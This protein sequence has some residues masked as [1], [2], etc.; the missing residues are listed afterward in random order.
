MLELSVKFQWIW[1]TYYY[2]FTR[3]INIAGKSN[4]AS[5]L[6]LIKCPIKWVISS[7]NRFGEISPICKHLEIF[8]IILKVYLIFG[9]VVNPCLGLFACLWAT[10]HRCKWP[11][12][13]KT[14]WPSNHTAV[15]LFRRHDL[16]F[17]LYIG[18]ATYLNIARM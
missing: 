11:N 18:Q 7:V 10:F 17:L 6:R 2:F 3:K 12:I 14:I 9:K 8:G 15:K 4:T 1:G 13:E 5:H 16:S